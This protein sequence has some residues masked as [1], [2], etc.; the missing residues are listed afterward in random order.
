MQNILKSFFITIYPVTAS[1]AFLYVSYQIIVNKEINIQLIALIIISFTVTRFFAFLFISPVARTNK[2]LWRHS[3]IIILGMVISCLS[4]NYDQMNKDSF[5]SSLFI[6]SGWYLY[7]NW[8]SVF[9]YR[10]RTLL[11]PGNILPDFE[12][13][14][15]EKNKIQSYSFIGSPTIFMFYRGNWCPLC[16]AQI[17]EVVKQYK[18]L[19]SRGV[20]TV[21]ISPQPHRHTKS[22]AKKF[23]VNFHFLVDAKNKTAKQLGLLSKNGLPAGL[24]TL[25]YSS[26]TVLPTVLITDSN[27]KLVFVNLTDNYRIRPEPGTFIKVVDAL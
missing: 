23:E 12:L 3:I 10:D 11:K 22:L 1:L 6:A 24:Q 5:Y 26:D 8:Y 14:N 27:G 4:Y 21:L 16:M 17:K 2:F 13:E 18:A 15:S 25:G 20:K 19:E 7:V 9:T